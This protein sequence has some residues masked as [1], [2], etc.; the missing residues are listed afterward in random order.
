MVVLLHLFHHE[1][2]KK[3]IMTKKQ[4]LFAIIAF[5][6]LILIGMFIKAF[7]PLA[8]GEEVRFKTLPRDPRD[9]FRGNYVDLSYS[10]NTIDLTALPNDIDK[11]GK[12]SYGDVFYLGIAPKGEFYEPTGIWNNPPKDTKY[13]QVIMQDD[14]SYSNYDTLRTMGIHAGIESYFT[15]KENALKIESLGANDSTDV[16]VKVMLAPDGKA[17]IKTVELRN[18][19]R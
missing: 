6:V 1:L 4:L 8:I 16:I 10:F 5:Q 9:L 15:E 2:L 13:M 11:M 7:Y 3:I 19:K 18:I 17:R 12:Y 14:Y